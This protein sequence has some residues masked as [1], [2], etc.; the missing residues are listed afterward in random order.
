M[1]LSQDAAHRATAA[2]SLQLLASAA[3]AYLSAGAAAPL[4]VACHRWR[5]RLRFLN[6]QL[7]GVINRIDNNTT[8]HTY[9][10]LK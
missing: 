4:L 6:L 1:H 10:R 2:L 9:T 3:D 7:R 8:S 5:R